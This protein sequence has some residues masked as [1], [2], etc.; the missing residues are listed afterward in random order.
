V[1]DWEPNKRLEF[2][3]VVVRTVLARLVGWS[4]KE[5]K[6]EKKEELEESPNDIIGNL[7]KSSILP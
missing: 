2:L 6:Q 5:M 1:E 4:R 7:T 3:K